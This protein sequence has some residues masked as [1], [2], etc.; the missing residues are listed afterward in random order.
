MVPSTSDGA[1]QHFLSELDS[2]NQSND[3]IVTD[4][5]SSPSTTTRNL[6]P[7]Q[8]ELLQTAMAALAQFVTS[9][10]SD[11]FVGHRPPFE[12]ES[13]TAPNY[14]CAM[15]TEE[16]IDLFQEKAPQARI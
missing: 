15:K 16:L 10:E 2:D 1:F 6:A 5:L 13:S 7:H 11:A 12:S 8:E 14:S 3:E 4:T 9:K